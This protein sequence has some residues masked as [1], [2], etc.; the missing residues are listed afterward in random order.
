ME[1]LTL[2]IATVEVVSLSSA[3]SSRTFA[4]VARRWR[5]AKVR[6]GMK[7]VMSIAAF[8]ALLPTSDAAIVWDESIDGDLLEIGQNIGPLQ[9]GTNTFR[10]TF[11]LFRSSGA[12]AH[13]DTDSGLVDLADGLMITSMDARITAT[14]GYGVSGYSRFAG[15]HAPSVNR[16]YDKEFSYHDGIVS[17]TVLVNLLPSNEMGTYRFFT[18]GG[19][20]GVA[21]DVEFY[22]DW[23]IDIEVTR[24]NQAIPEPSGFLIW[25]ILTA[26]TGCVSARRNRKE[27][28]KRTSCSAQPLT[29]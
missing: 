13:A 19:S 20:A 11:A 23:E 28:R 18:G 5:P 8:F 1:R 25:S 2:P 6:H 24:D 29:P 17:E 9:V 21:D 16:I 3:R 27:L 15:L 26:T 10:G 7:H 12:A 22:W 4:M 14:Y